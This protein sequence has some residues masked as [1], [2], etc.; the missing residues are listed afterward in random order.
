[1]VRWLQW[2][3]SVEFNIH[4]DNCALDLKASDL[5]LYIMYIVYVA[6]IS[7]VYHVD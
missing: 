2:V 3:S 6:H 4:Y 1:M 7:F 5:R